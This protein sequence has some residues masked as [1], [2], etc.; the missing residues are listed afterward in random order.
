MCSLEFEDHR[1]LYDWVLDQ[2]A[3]PSR[4]VQI[5]FGRLNIGYTVTSKRKLAML[6]IGRSCARMGRSPHA[7]TERLP[8]ARLYSGI[9]PQFLPDCGSRQS[10]ETTWSWKW[11]CW[12]TRCARISTGMRARVMGVL[13]PLR[14]V[15]EN[16]PEGQTEELDAVNNPADPESG[17]RKVPFSRVIYIEQDD[18]REDPPKKFFRLSPGREVR[19]RYAYFITCTS[20]VKDDAEGRLSSCDAPTILQR[21]AGI[22]RTDDLRKRR[23]I[24]FP[25]HMPFR[26]RFDS[27]TGCSPKNA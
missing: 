11:R 18:F 22:H 6:V 16:Y 8:A 7:H 24:G 25:L 19:L 12:N 10:A 20:V 9:H 27:T 5:E 14:V 3:L 26:R 13:N 15:I 21:A 17:T 4:P 23:C 1:P 2:F